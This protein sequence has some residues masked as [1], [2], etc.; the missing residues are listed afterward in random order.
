MIP[1]HANAND[2]VRQQ[3][4]LMKYCRAKQSCQC[5]DYV[6]NSAN[7]QHVMMVRSLH[8]FCEAL[9]EWEQ[10]DHDTIYYLDQQE[11]HQP[12]LN[13]TTIINH[14]SIWFHVLFSLSNQKYPRHED[15]LC[16]VEVRKSDRLSN[17]QPAS[18]KTPLGWLLTLWPRSRN[19][20]SPNFLSKPKN[21]HKPTFHFPSGEVPSLICNLVHQNRSQRGSNSR[22]SYK[23]PKVPSSSRPLP[24]Y[25]LHVTVT[26]DADTAW[27][28]PFTELWR[29][30]RHIL[31][32]SYQRHSVAV[33]NIAD[34]KEEGREA[35]GNVCP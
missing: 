33:A 23:T 7:V 32:M 22:G 29:G 8:T 27:N 26:S 21:N 5:T 15:G 28:V 24:G 18:S 9:S 20:P 34:V 11:Q 2:D 35:N 30:W 13:I 12:K 14:L 4:W 17:R 25:H 3:R 10:H 31:N 16:C 19:G 6:I 1:L